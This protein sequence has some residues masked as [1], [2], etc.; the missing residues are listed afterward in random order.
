[1]RAKAPLDER[2]MRRL[3][4]RELHILL[5]PTMFMTRVRL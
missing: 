2:V 5:T 3:K 4:L 1:M